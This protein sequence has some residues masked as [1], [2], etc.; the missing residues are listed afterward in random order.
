MD[1]FEREDVRE[2]ARAFTDAPSEAPGPWSGAH[3][4]WKPERE[5]PK[6]W[7]RLGWAL[8]FDFVRPTIGRV[9]A[10]RS[11]PFETVHR[12]IRIG[13][14][15]EAT[16][17]P[18]QLSLTNSVHGIVAYLDL[19]VVRAIRRNSGPELAAA[20]AS[21]AGHR[22]I[23]MGGGLIAHQLAQGHST[24]YQTVLPGRGELKK[25]LNV[26]AD[27][28]TALLDGGRAFTAEGPGW[29][30]G[31]LFTYTER[32]AAVG[33]HAA[34]ILNWT[35]DL[36]KPKG[37]LTAIPPYDGARPDIGPRPGGQVIDA[38]WWIYGLMQARSRELAKR[39][40]VAIT[41]ADW[42]E[43]RDATGLSA[44]SAA[45]LREYEDPEKADRLKWTS[46]RTRTWV[47]RTDPGRYRLTDTNAH[48]FLLEQGGRREQG[49]L[50][51]KRS[52]EK[53]AGKLPGRRK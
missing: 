52:A 44:K 11:A 39:G 33:R 14:T 45:R 29:K 9:P 26:D 3:G 38:T 46:G 53:R 12:G 10:M 1:A 21:T 51:G 36:F 4:P 2:A 43:M 37:L 41:D 25:I 49:A 6:A 30:V 19:R 32:K 47:V 16:D 27:R 5:T 24:P 15:T 42:R 50:H 7:L 13:N 28:L 20:L 40:S 31:G 18:R 22:L 48:N 23:S 34:T 8:W 17:D 35:P